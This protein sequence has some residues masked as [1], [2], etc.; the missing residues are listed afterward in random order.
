MRNDKDYK[1]REIERGGGEV[2]GGSLLLRFSTGCECLIT[3]LQQLLGGHGDLL[4]GEIIQFESLH[5][6]PLSVC[7]GDGEGEDETFGDPIRSI[8]GH[9]HRHEYSLGGSL[10]PVVDVVA[11]SLGSRHGRRQ[12]PLLDDHCSSLLHRL[13][14]SSLE[15]LGIS[16]CRHGVHFSR[17][18]RHLRMAHIRELSGRVIS[19]DDHILH[20]AHRD[21]RLE[22]HLCG[23]AIVIE[24][25]H[26][27]EIAR[28]NLPCCVLRTDEGI[29]VSG[30]ANDD[31]LGG[32]LGEVGQ[33]LSLRLEDAHVGSE[34]ILSL[35]SFLSRHSSD[36]ES[37]VDVG[38]G[39]LLISDCL[40]SGEIGEGAVS[41]FELNSLEDSS[42]G[43]DIEE[44]EHDGGLLPE[45]ISLG[46]LENQR[47]SNLTSSAS[48]ENTKGSC[49][50]HS[51]RKGKL[52]I[53]KR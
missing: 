46:D 44:D 20:V 47:V 45:H 39:I 26:G 42:H 48:D 22:C 41:Q 40:H 11:C 7:D 52:D 43:R 6:L 35:H 23:G 17:A 18:L 4:L 50:F 13:D 30:V 31:H 2:R 38:E 27:G 24:S 8:G 29:R 1:L 12:L 37:V 10:V 14:E 21:S 36:E 3:L 51:T 32:G 49:H 33:S 5:D 15:P 16:H 28:G 53:Q 19:P 25:G 34:Q 9:C